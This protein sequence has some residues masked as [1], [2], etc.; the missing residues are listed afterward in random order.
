MVKK[1]KKIILL[2]FGFF[3]L[4]ANEIKDIDLI[5]LDKEC[6]EKKISQILC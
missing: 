1:V 2:F 3:Y 6:N 5:K 4:F